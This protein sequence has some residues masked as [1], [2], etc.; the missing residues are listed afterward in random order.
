MTPC[1]VVYIPNFS[2]EIATSF[3]NHSDDVD[4]WFLCNIHICVSV[5]VCV[6]VCVTSQEASGFVIVVHTILHL[7]I[8]EPS[9]PT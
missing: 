2:V 9:V 8:I 5:W 6:Y 3:F 1:S 7:T 4:S